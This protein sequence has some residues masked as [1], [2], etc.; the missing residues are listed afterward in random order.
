MF[1]ATGT[2][3]LTKGTF[4]GEK[5]R[6]SRC[7]N[8]G[9]PDLQAGGGRRGKR[10]LMASL[11]KFKWDGIGSMFEKNLLKDLNGSGGLHINVVQRV[12]LCR[13]V[14]MCRIFL[15][16]GFVFFDFDRGNLGLNYFI[17]ASCTLDLV[18]SVPGTDAF[19]DG[20]VDGVA[21]VLVL[22]HESFRSG[23]I[24][25]QLFCSLV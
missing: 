22:A 1:S 19:E 6:Q 23:V 13:I 17:G 24:Y 5:V 10:V 18:D 16:G 7:L 9:W 8:R 11:K 20:S 3:H 12:F 4:T 14:I 21:V 15:W 2:S 25:L